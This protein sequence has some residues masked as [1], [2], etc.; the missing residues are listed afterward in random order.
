MKFMRV[1]AVAAVA[2]AAM[3]VAGA[4]DADAGPR[5]SSRVH[6]LVA[7]PGKCGPNFYWSSKACKCLDARWKTHVP[8]Y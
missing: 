4:P 7:P 6:G 1:L 5:Y 8:N 3:T 2:A